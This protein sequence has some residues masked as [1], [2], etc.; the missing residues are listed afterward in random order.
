MGIPIEIILYQNPNFKS[1]Q[2]EMLYRTMINGN[3]YPFDNN[4]YVNFRIDHHQITSLPADDNGINKQE[5]AIKFAQENNVPIS[6]QFSEIAT[7]RNVTL[8]HN[9]HEYKFHLEIKKSDD[10]YKMFNDF[11]KSI[12]ENIPVEFH[13]NKIE[14]IS[15]HNEEIVRCETNLYH[16]GVLIL[17]SSNKLKSYFFSH[18]F[19]YDFPNGLEELLTSCSIIAINAYDSGFIT[20]IDFDNIEKNNKA[21]AS[22]I[23]VE[24]KSIKGDIIFENK[25]DELLLLNHADFTMI[26]N[27]HKG[28]YKHYGWKHIISIPMISKGRQRFKIWKEN[29]INGDKLIFQTAPT[30]P[31]LDENKLINL[32]EIPTNNK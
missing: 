11:H 5:Q 17:A 20:I 10:Q 1:S 25:Y 21:I 31:K 9:E 2:I 24:G 29:T 4:G 22:N 23:Y 32:E 3:F 26:C 16:E 19:N 7:K 15:N 8:I 6:I 13:M 12:K 30:E 27:Y 28:D 14:W 18:T